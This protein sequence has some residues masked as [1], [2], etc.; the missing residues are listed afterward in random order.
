MFSWEEISSFGSLRERDRFLTWMRGQIANGLADEVRAPLGGPPDTRDRWFRH[1]PT[2]ALWRLVPDENP[3]GPGFWP[4][5][6]E[7]A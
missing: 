5:R 7:A 6:E 2:G 3:F 4:V 1:V